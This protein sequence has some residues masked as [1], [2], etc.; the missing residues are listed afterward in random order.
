MTKRTLDKHKKEILKTV[1]ISYAPTAKSVSALIFSG[2]IS[3]FGIYSLI[4]GAVKEDYVSV[5]LGIFILILIVADTFKRGAL[6]RYYNSQIR[7]YITGKGKVLKM[8]LVIFFLSLAFMSVFDIVGAFS[9]AKYANQAYQDFS[10]THSKEFDLLEQNAK[11]GKDNL[12]IYTKELEAWQQDKR[13]A[14]QTCNEKW[15]GWKAKYK[16]KCKQD[17]EKKNPK[18]TKP[19]S[20]GKIKVDDYKKIKED[21]NQDFLSKY[22]YYIVLFL[23]LALTAIL[24]YTTISEIQDEKDEIEEML[25]PQLAGTLQDRLLILENNAIE[26]ET[27]RNELI[28]K[29]DQAHKKE[30]RKF[31]ELGE[32][33]KILSL[34]KATISRGETIKRISNNVPY[35]K[36]EPTAKAGFV[37][38]GAMP[39]EEP[40]REEPKQD[41]FNGSNTEFLI[42]RLWDNGKVKA[43]KKLVPKS[44]TININRRKEVEAIGNLYRILVEKKA[45][46]MKGVNGGY[47][48]LVDMEK[49]IDLYWDWKYGYSNNSTNSKSANYDFDLGEY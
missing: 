26:H 32:G 31:E 42:R 45:I 39:T 24:Q 20:T 44:K 30:T 28:R 29:S 21:V 6:S 36:E 13:D 11:A 9:T 14:Y 43:N 17:W 37:N 41:P 7:H 25:T 40:K 8:Q 27:E 22:L 49:A 5:A 46:K 19:N 12:N 10:T 33:M 18:P 3:T 1:Q 34:Q 23:S 47:Y 15:R 48:A 35:S 4:A 2:A 16:A 38:F